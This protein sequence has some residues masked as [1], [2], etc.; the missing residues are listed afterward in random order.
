MCTLS[1]LCDS[2][3]HD[4]T[5]GAEGKWL[6]VR[7][8]GRAVPCQEWVAGLCRAAAVRNTEEPGPRVHRAGGLS[9]Q[10]QPGGQGSREVADCGGSSR[11]ECRFVCW[12]EWLC[13]PSAFSGRPAVLSNTDVFWTVH[14]EG[15]G[16]WKFILNLFSVRFFSLPFKCIIFL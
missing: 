1:P 6:A 12:E 2:L 9:W 4:P 8:E 13:L 15:G 3:N 11:R 16:I 5:S 7:P 10:G 14:D